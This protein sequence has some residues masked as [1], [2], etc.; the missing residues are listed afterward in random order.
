MMKEVE[1]TGGNP[2]D[3]PKTDATF[4]THDFAIGGVGGNPTFRAGTNSVTLHNKGKQIHEIDLFELAEGKMVEDVVAWAAKLQ[5][6][7]PGRFLGGPAVRGGLAVTT[8]FEMKAGPLYALVCI[9]PDSLG[10]GAPHITKGM[11]TEEFQAQP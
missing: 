4:L 5:G 8:T 10:D 3:L 6:P 11:H 1:A 9:V 2:G 7:P